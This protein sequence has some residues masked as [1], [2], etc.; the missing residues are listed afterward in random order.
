MASQKVSTKHGIKQFVCCG[1]PKFSGPKKKNIG[2]NPTPGNAPSP[3]WSSEDLLLR[4][5]IVH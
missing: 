5:L 2:I 1:F 4:T 3:W